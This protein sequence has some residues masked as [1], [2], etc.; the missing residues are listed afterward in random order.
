[1]PNNLDRRGRT[2]GWISEG[3]KSILCLICAAPSIILY[4]RATVSNGSEWILRLRWALLLRPDNTYTMYQS[5]QTAPWHSCSNRISTERTSS[6]SLRRRLSM[7]VHLKYLPPG[8]GTLDIHCTDDRT[9][10]NSSKHLHS[11]EKD[12]SGGDNLENVPGPEIFG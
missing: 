3:N 9:F 8:T 7:P 1:M 11:N 12:S 5:L 2:D 4:H 6:G 10:G